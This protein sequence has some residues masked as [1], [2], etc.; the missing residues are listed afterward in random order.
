MGHPVFPLS[1]LSA[2]Y[3][4]AY[5]E[6]QRRR[7]KRDSGEVE[8]TIEPL[9]STD[10]NSTLVPVNNENIEGEFENNTMLENLEND[11]EDG[12]NPEG[13]IED[14]DEVSSEN[15]PESEEDHSSSEERQVCFH[16]LYGQMKHL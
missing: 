11:S 1:R 14:E 12:P 6:Q 2:A 4:N 7:L 13:N 9:N 5:Q 15:L 10:L 3:Q 8:D 16:Y